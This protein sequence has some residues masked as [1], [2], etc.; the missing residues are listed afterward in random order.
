MAGNRLNKSSGNKKNTSKKSK[1]NKSAKDQSVNREGYF[2]SHIK[3]AKEAFVTIWQRPLGSILTLAVIAM[4]LALPSTIYL[5][6]K[7]VAEVANGA[8]NRPVVNV[9][10]KEGIS[11]ARIMVLKDE[12]ESWELVKSVDYISSQQGLSDLSQS[13]GFEQAIS[14][15]SDYSLPA[16]LVISPMQDESSQIKEIANRAK[17]QESI[18]DVRLDEDWLARLDAIKSLANLVSITLAVL[19][20]SAVFLI[21]GN[22]LRFTVLAHKEEIQVMKLIGATDSFILRPYL[23]SGM[24]FGVIGAL[25]A[26]IFTAVIIVVLNGEVEGLAQLYDSQFRLIGL[27]LDESVLLLMLG[28]FLGYTAA[29]FAARKHLKEIEPV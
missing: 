18:T 24:W 25:F 29:R 27:K 14:L 8:S 16:V 1:A 15:L 10:L 28:L 23:Y 20:L 11:E 5:V 4:A 2:K 3:H 13:A 19:M 6:G 12:L 9:Y 17:Q 7:N 26:W 22:T 21:V